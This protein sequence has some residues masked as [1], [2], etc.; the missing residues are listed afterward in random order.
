MKPLYWKFIVFTH[1]Q[2]PFQRSLLIIWDD[3]WSDMSEW[4]GNRA[5]LRVWTSR[6]KKVWGGECGTGCR[7]MDDRPVDMRK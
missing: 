5:H 6:R 7:S 3:R 1:K 4:M 2:F